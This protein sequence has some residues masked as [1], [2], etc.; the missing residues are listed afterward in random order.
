MWGPQND[1]DD[2]LKETGTETGAERVDV[3]FSGKEGVTTENRKV[4]VA[5]EYAQRGAGE[6][7]ARSLDNKDFSSDAKAT[8]RSVPKADLDDAADD[9]VS[10]IAARVLK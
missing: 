6:V 2:D 7:K 9:A 1:L 8:T 5:V 10:A 4:R 3:T